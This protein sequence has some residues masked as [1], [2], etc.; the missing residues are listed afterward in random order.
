MNFTKTFNAAHMVLLR[1]IEFSDRTY[2]N[3][4]R[5]VLP[6]LRRARTSKMNDARVAL[7]PERLQ[8]AVRQARR[9]NTFI[10]RLK[11]AYRGDL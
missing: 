11:V 2:G 4:V 9:A 8:S 6:Q 5:K 10:V 1:D 7:T 3:I